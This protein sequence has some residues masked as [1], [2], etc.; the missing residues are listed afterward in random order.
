MYLKQRTEAKHNYD[1]YGSLRFYFDMMVRDFD[2][3]VGIHRY[4]KDF[5]HF[6]HAIDSVY[7]YS[8]KEE[9]FNMSIEDL[10]NVKRARLLYVQVDSNYKHVPIDWFMNYD[11]FAIYTFLNLVGYGEGSL[12]GWMRPFFRAENKFIVD[13]KKDFFN[14]GQGGLVSFFWQKLKTVLYV[15]WDMLFMVSITSVVV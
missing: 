2:S 10:M 13:F 8:N 12:G 7:I 5:L 14:Y 4:I 3:F 1:Y 6:R 9:F 15:L 11:S